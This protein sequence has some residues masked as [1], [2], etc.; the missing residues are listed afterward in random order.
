MHLPVLKKEVLEI[1]DPKPNQ[2]FVDA[3][4]G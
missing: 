3:T 4:F 2:N 1:L